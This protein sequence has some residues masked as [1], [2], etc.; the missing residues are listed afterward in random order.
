MYD[1]EV[2]ATVPFKDLVHAGLQS[3]KK[4]CCQMWSQF[5]AMR[6][7]KFRKKA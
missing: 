4:H 2:I 7:E 5:A 6:K 3:Q 1:M